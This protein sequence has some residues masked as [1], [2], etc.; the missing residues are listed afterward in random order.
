MIQ[1][2]MVQYDTRRYGTVRYVLEN[3]ISFMFWIVGWSKQT[4]DIT[5]GKLSFFFLF[6]NF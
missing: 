6:H 5:S 4:S 3:R 2:V 1:Y